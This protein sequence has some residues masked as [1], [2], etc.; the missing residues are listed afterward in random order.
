MDTWDSDLAGQVHEFEVNQRPQ[1]HPEAGAV[2][3]AVIRISL[4]F[5]VSGLHSH[6]KY[7]VFFVS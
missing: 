5:V 2:R 7:H 1:Y 4:V 6:A 3:T